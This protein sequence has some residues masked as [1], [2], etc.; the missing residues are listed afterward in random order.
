MLDCEDNSCLEKKISSHSQVASSYLSSLSRLQN[1]FVVVFCANLCENLES[2]EKKYK[3]VGR[4][5]DTGSPKR[6]IYTHGRGREG[7]S[8]V[9]NVLFF[10]RCST[11]REF[12]RR[13]ITCVHIADGEDGMKYLVFIFSRW[14]ARKVGKKNQSD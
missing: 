13:N 11:F 2:E 10:S 5:T 6:D 7:E 3:L 9:K 12:E 4:A 8:V 1:V 14:H